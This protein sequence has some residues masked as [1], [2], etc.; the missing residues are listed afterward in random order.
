MVLTR[1]IFVGGV[2]GVGKTSFCKNLSDKFD[3]EYVTASSLIRR[4]SK[5]PVNKTV[6][7]VGGNQSILLD[8]LSHYLTNRSTLLLDG[9]F[10]LLKNTLEFEDVPLSIFVA[11]D[12]CAIFLLKDN[13]S[14]IVMRLSQRDN[15]EH[16]VSR[17]AALQEREVH[18]ARL[19]SENLGIPFV[20]VE[21]ILDYEGSLK[22]VI[23]YL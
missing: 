22:A 17:I 13:P 19:V 20:I 16:D 9:H 8:E 15:K 14:T 10:C 5:L 12:P 6:T 7:D 3:L 11:I 2:H 1:T 21:P 18:R 23:P 4:R